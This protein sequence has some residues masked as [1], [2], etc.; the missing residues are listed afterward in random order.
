ALA[1]QTCERVGDG[2]RDYWNRWFAAAGW[3]FSARHDVNVDR[4]R[5]IDDVRRSVTVEV[6]LFDDA[7][8]QRDR[9]FRHELRQ[10]KPESRLKLTLDRE[11]IHRE[12][13]IDC[14]GRTMN[15]R[16]LVLDRHIDRACHARIERLVT[17]N[18]ERVS[19]RQLVAPTGG[20]F[21][22]QLE[23]A[24]QLFRVGLE[25]LLTI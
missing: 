19:A 11:W 22:E 8:L 25:Q 3:R 4:H 13:A 17:R 14:H 24:Q 15:L 12:S 21:I 1:G 23:R 16:P 20:L 7:V 9:A 10:A 6:A 18:T 5:C 2:R